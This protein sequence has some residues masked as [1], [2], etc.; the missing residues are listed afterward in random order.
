MELFLLLV[1]LLQEP[2]PV[3]P[4]IPLPLDLIHVDTVSCSLIEYEAAEVLNAKTGEVTEIKKWRVEPYA[5]YDDHRDRWEL[6]QEQLPNS[7]RMRP[8]SIANVDSDFE[9]LTV[10][11]AWREKAKQAI[12][13][14]RR[15]A[16]HPKKK[17]DK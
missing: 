4:P 10:C 1:L 6:P 9:A 8:G 7:K 16:V 11:R 15:K 12:E 5:T 2:V 3:A 17:V 14:A 13:E